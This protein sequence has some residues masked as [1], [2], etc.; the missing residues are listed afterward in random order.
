MRG[1]LERRET[2]VDDMNGR[3]LYQSEHETDPEKWGFC[4]NS[5]RTDRRCP[6]RHTM[7]KHL[8]I[9]RLCPEDG[10]V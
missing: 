5:D 3:D 8:C 10:D 4:W 6:H 1:N 9:S 2:A 7:N